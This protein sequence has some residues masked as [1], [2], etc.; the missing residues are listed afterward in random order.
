LP[1]WRGEQEFIGFAVVRRAWVGDDGEHV[2]REFG[3][4]GWRKTDYSLSRWCT[5]AYS[6]Q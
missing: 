2:R 1:A 4:D 3:N 6:T 5:L